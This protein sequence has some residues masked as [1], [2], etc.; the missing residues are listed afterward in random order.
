M[1][2]HSPQVDDRTLAPD[3]LTVHEAALV[4]RIGR[5]TA[6]EMVN[7]FLAGNTDE[8]LPARRVGRQ[9][10]VPR[11][12]LER[13]H[14]G[15]ITWPPPAARIDEPLEATGTDP[16]TFARPLDTP[17]RRSSRP[18]TWSQLELLAD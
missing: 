18:A 4:L 13:W 16:L 14:G 15:P 1:D 7:K 8:G 11:A 12:A 3:F 17:L 5:T 6:Y 2:R 9:L 10:R